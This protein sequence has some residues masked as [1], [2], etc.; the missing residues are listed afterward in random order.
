MHFT[1][2]CH[3]FIFFGH[4]STCLPSVCLYSATNVYILLR[5]V[6]NVPAKA[7]Y[8]SLGLVVQSLGENGQQGLPLSPIPSEEW[9]RTDLLCWVLL[10]SWCWGGRLSTIL[11]STSFSASAP[12]SVWR[13]HPVTLGLAVSGVCCCTEKWAIVTNQDDHLI[14]RAEVVLNLQC[15]KVSTLFCTC[16]YLDFQYTGHK[17]YMLSNSAVQLEF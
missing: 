6:Q 7:F 1:F 4:F 9:W 10:L 14:C 11:S 5:Q 8:Q 13:K 12:V 16:M 2:F 17:G 15:C 3:S